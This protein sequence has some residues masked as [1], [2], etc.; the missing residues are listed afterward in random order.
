[1]MAIAFSR[2]CSQY[3]NRTFPQSTR[4]PL[5]FPQNAKGRSP[6]MFP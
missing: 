5:K 3:T 2:S 1:M 4:S 6:L